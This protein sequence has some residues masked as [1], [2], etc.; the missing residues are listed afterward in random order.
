MADII[1][2]KKCKGSGE[3]ETHVGEKRNCDVC[4]G[5]G[6]IQFGIDDFA[7]G[8]R[9]HNLVVQPEEAGAGM[10]LSPMHDPDVWDDFPE[11]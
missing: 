6:M 11:K 10:Y 9:S 4:D 5:N 3:V 7:R 1:I 2:C 8:H